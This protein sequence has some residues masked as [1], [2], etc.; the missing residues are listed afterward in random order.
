MRVI[1]QFLSPLLFSFLQET[2]PTIILHYDTSC[3]D[4]SWEGYDY[5]TT[6]HNFNTN[7]YKINLHKQ[8]Q[9]S[10]FSF[11]GTYNWK[12]QLTS[13]LQ[14]YL[15]VFDRILTEQFHLLKQFLYPVVSFFYQF[16]IKN[17]M[18]QYWCKI[19]R[20]QA[21]DGSGKALIS[22]TFV[23]LLW[24]QPLSVSFW[25]YLVNFVHCLCSQDSRK[26]TAYDHHDVQRNHSRQ[27]RLPQ[28]LDESRKDDSQTRNGEWE[29]VICSRKPR[30]I[31][32]T[33]ISFPSFRW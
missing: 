25:T 10:L 30:W 15:K 32:F 18:K 7:C 11:V 14:I 19:S 24:T 9:R 13:R 17:R 8:W 20:L 26:W 6:C 16:K 1:L 3:Y 22:K 33:T 12:S 31:L 2:L 29:N 23:D 21:R 28:I 5:A 4:I 27:I